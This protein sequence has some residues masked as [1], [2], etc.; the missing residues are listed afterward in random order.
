MYAQSDE[1]VAVPQLLRQAT[2]FSGEVT[3]SLQAMDRI[4]ASDWATLSTLLTQLI[5]SLNTN[6]TLTPFMAI[7]PSLLCRVMFKCFDPKGVMGVHRKA[8][9]VLQRLFQGMGT[10]SLLQ[11]MPLLLVGVL[12][13]LPQCSMQLK[14]DL[15]IFIDTHVLRVL[16]ADM[17]VLQLPGIFAAVLGGVEE[18]GG[19]E[20]YQLSLQLVENIHSIVSKWDAMGVNNCNEATGRYVGEGKSLERA[21]ADRGDAVVY[22]ALW[23]TLKNSPSLRSAVLQYLKLRISSEANRP[24][25]YSNEEPMGEECDPMEQKGAAEHTS[26]GSPAAFLG[27]DPTVAHGAIFI[28]LQDGSERVRRLMLDILLSAIPLGDRSSFTF[29]EQSLLV[30]AA[31]QLLGLPETNSST[32]RRVREWLMGPSSDGVFHFMHNDSFFHVAQAFHGLTQ[33]WKLRFSAVADSQPQASVGEMDPLCQAHYQALQLSAVRCLQET[34]ANFRPAKGVTGVG[35]EN[36]DESVE[37]YALPVVWLKAL[38]VLLES[39]ADGVAADDTRPEAT[40]ECTE[41]SSAGNGVSL[42]RSVSSPFVE[43]VMPLLMPYMCEL[44]VAIQLRREDGAAGCSAIDTAFKSFFSVV[45]W[46]Y[47]TRYERGIVSILEKSVD[48]L[49]E[50]GASPDALCHSLSADENL[51]LSVGSMS[52]QGKSTES[53]QTRVSNR[54]AAFLSTLHHRFRQFKAMATIIRMHADELLHSETQAADFHEELLAMCYSF[55]TLL[56][57]GC[58]MAAT[59]LETAGADAPT[60]AYHEAT[61]LCTIRHLIDGCLCMLHFIASDVLPTI[62]K[63]TVSGADS[64]TTVNG[65][66]TDLLTLLMRGASAVTRLV[67]LS[68]SEWSSLFTCAS[69]SVI[70]FLSCVPSPSSDSKRELLEVALDDWLES[71]A[72]A[73][74]SGP[75]TLQRDAQQLFVGLLQSDNLP[76]VLRKVIQSEE[77]LPH[78]DAKR[79]RH[80]QG[81]YKSLLVTHLWRLVGTCTPEMQP[82]VVFLLLRLYAGK[83]ERI[84]LD[85]IT[86]EDTVE[87]IDRIAVLFYWLAECDAEY[88]LFIPALNM[89]LRALYHR[90][91]TARWR[92]QS[93]LR[94]SIPYFHRIFNPMLA[95]LTRQLT[96]LNEVASGHAG[97]KSAVGGASLQC[98]DGNTELQVRDAYELNPTEFVLVVHCML[99]LPSFTPQMLQRV[100]QLPALADAEEKL[101]LL[102]SSPPYCLQKSNLEDSVNPDME[103]K[104]PAFATLVH[105]LLAVACHSSLSQS[106]GFSPDDVPPNVEMGISAIE[107]LNTLLRWSRD[108]P[109]SMEVVSLTWGGTLPQ[110]V[111]LL[112]RAVKFRMYPAEQVALLQYLLDVLRIVGD[113]ALLKESLPS[114][115]NTLQRCPSALRSRIFLEALEAGIQQAVVNATSPPRDPPNHDLLLAWCDALLS[116]LPFLHNKCDEVSMHAIV[117][118]VRVIEGQLHDSTVSVGCN[119]L[120]VVETCLNSIYGVMEHHLLMGKSPAQGVADAKV[121]R[122]GKWFHARVSFFGNN[123]SSS[124]KSPKVATDSVETVRQFMHLVV[125]A[126]CRVYCYTRKLGGCEGARHPETPLCEERR[127]DIVRT[128]VNAQALHGGSRAAS[129]TAHTL[130]VEKALLRIVAMYMELAMLDFFQKFIEVWVSN[131]A[132]KL[133]DWMVEPH[134]DVA[135]HTGLMRFE[136]ASQDF[137]SPPP[138]FE[139]LSQMLLSA[140]TSATT[141]SLVRAAKDFLLQAKSTSTGSPLWSREVFGLDVPFDAALFYF[142]YTFLRV[143][144]KPPEDMAQLGD[145]L[146]DLFNVRLSSGSVSLVSLSFMLL[147][148]A[149]FVSHTRHEGDKDDGVAALNGLGKDK[150]YPL[151]VCRVLDAVSS[152]GSGVTLRDQRGLHFALVVM[153]QTITVIVRTAQVEHDRVAA[154]IH[155]LYKRTVFPL[156]VAGVV[157]SAD[158]EARAHVATAEISLRLTATLVDTNDS[159]LRRLR[160]EI[161]ESICMYDFLNFS[162]GMLRQCSV[163]FAR[164][165]RD[166][167][168]HAEM[169]PLLGLSSPAMSRLGSLPSSAEDDRQQR[170][171]QLRRLSFYVMSI[172][173]SHLT[174]ER[175]FCRLLREYVAE[176]FRTFSSVASE[177]RP[178]M[179]TI[180]QHTLFLFR[181]LL[182]K[183]DQSLLQPFWALILAEMVRILVDIPNS[184]LPEATGTLADDRNGNERSVWALRLECL[185]VMQFAMVIMPEALPSFRWVFFDDMCTFASRS[186]GS[187][188]GPRIFIPLFARIMPTGAP[189]SLLFDAQQASLP[190]EKTSSASWSGTQRPLLHLPLL[191]SGTSTAVRICTA[192]LIVMSPLGDLTR[193]SEIAS[194]Q[195]QLVMSMRLIDGWDEACILNLLEAEFSCSHE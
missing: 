30:A 41:G 130:R 79:K 194:A 153:N 92:A 118:F 158:D 17:I 139:A 187:L 107:T 104:I 193:I 51:S 11:Q 24:S 49:L 61:A 85:S 185:K 64:E 66:S 105:A 184:P 138:D 127:G 52:G 84:L 16:P 28:T 114:P 94:Q 108:V 50:R 133:S 172:P 121:S 75:I 55:S 25:N 145:V 195:E 26:V 157:T 70:A 59:Q 57:E 167:V 47:L 161:L 33:W 191:S 29:T 144:H 6:A 183:L 19:S 18:G 2:R 39:G 112:H 119:R 113:A 54:N 22:R 151:L 168:F 12:N 40:D 48:R 93:M 46:E 115:T 76:P 192:A 8:L 98:V 141:L 174:S 140:G 116:L 177:N 97:E 5:K 7:D 15:L 82:D 10:L 103:Q 160:Q 124:V 31:V 100:C 162:S 159:I 42:T 123:S 65:R 81:S 163:L 173:A 137:T 136:S 44:L 156:I 148:M 4:P 27:S 60:A 111:V 73:A 128:F 142:L 78:T 170:S 74:C 120:R 56:L 186:H 20:V 1:S 149:N 131:Y 21:L 126:V 166:R 154:S 189:E 146:L 178:R 77:E 62:P 122:G 90:N 117:A 36:E 179:Y 99:S 182:T 102:L 96:I 80:S 175:D 69:D 32:R 150:R 53:M 83:K 45:P 34:K 101:Q 190:L 132:P 88:D 165:S 171:S 169:I 23:F 43:R 176:T 164:L 9:E 89:V 37:I 72:E 35:V 58:N 155:N 95:S 109:R 135:Q 13:L 125:T 129:E 91:T 14:R 3:K 67:A 134:H 71:I 63:L 110:A 181:V 86:S 152:H 147:T 38:T 143:S 87:N 180:V 68:P 106:E 188:Y